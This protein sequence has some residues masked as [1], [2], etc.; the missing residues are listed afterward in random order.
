MKRKIINIEEEKCNGCGACAKS[1]HEGAIVMINS[2]AKLIRD[3]YCDGLG[4]CL[5]VCPTGAISVIERE[6]APY[7]EAA[8]QEKTRNS[9]QKFCLSLVRGQKSER[10]STVKIHVLLLTKKVQVS[11]PSGRYR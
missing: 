11:F 2:K 10:L 3:D 1:C 6:A 8:V 7:N 5:P 9:S 4:D